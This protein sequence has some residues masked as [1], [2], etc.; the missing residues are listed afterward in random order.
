[1]SL[2]SLLFLLTTIND[3]IKESIIVNTRW[4][5]L[6]WFLLGILFV[7]YVIFSL[8]TIKYQLRLIITHLNIN[9]E[10]SKVPDEEIERELEEDKKG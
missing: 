3:K 8:S 1:M 9:E 6:I 4:D 10:P 5:F 2:V 7:I